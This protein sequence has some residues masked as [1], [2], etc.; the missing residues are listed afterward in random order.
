VCV[1]CVCVCV[2]VCECGCVCVGVG[3]CD[4]QLRERT[5]GELP[6]AASIQPSSSVR[7]QPLPPPPG[8]AADQSP[9]AAREPLHGRSYG[10]TSVLVGG[11]VSLYE[12]AGGRG[13]VTAAACGATALRIS[14]SPELPTW[15][16]PSITTAD[17]P[18]QHKTRARA[19][20]E[21][22]WPRLTGRCCRCPA[23][24][25][26]S[27]A[28]ATAPPQRSRPHLATGPAAPPAHPARRTHT[29][30]W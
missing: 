24:E 19:V 14:I 6:A 29:L 30:F 8:P 18:T 22:C 16:Q 20:L 23:S 21:Y 4:T 26:R 5:A 13:G 11:Y 10:R 17:T 2:S 12:G 27:C 15:V 3:V 28:V 1:V 9:P 25:R 7:P